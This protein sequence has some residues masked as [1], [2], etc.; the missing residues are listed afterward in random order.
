MPLITS[1][2]ISLLSLL[3]MGFFYFVLETKQDFI[4]IGLFFLMAGL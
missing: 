4:D 3:P 1:I 2:L